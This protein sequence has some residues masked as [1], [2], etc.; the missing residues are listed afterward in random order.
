MSLAPTEINFPFQPLNRFSN[1]SSTVFQ[2]NFLK[3]HRNA[4]VSKRERAQF[5]SKQ[6]GVEFLLLFS[7]TT[8][9]LREFKPQPPKIILAAENDPQCCCKPQPPKII[10]AAENDPPCCYES[11]PSV[12]VYLYSRQLFRHTHTH[13]RSF[14]FLA[15]S[16]SWSKKDH[17]VIISILQCVDKPSSTKCGITLSCII[18]LSH[19]AG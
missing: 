12:E 9:L 3:M 4:Q 2:S 14:R 19:P 7:L 8:V 6:Q 16:R 18:L 10:L 15:C 5:A 17:S 1:L 13:R 11:S